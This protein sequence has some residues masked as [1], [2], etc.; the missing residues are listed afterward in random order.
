MERG[1]KQFL[2]TLGVR[3][4]PFALSR[5]GTTEPV[6]AGPS[7]VSRTDRGAVALRRCKGEAPHNTGSRYRSFTIAAQGWGL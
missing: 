7:Q 2:A 4:A 6:A 3:A 5:N 1:A